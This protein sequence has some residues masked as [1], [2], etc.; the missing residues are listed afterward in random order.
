[1][2]AASVVILGLVLAACHFERADSGRPAGT[3]TAADSVVRSEEDSAAAE[4]VRRML[5]GYYDRV[6]HRGWGALAQ[7]FWRG[8]VISNRWVPP[9]DRAARLSLTGVDEYVRQLREGPGRSASFAVDPVSM[10]VRV[11]GDVAEAWVVYKLRSGTRAAPKTRY[12]VDALH[13]VRHEGAWR[14]VSLAYTAEDPERPLVAPAPP[15]A[16]AGAAAAGAPGASRR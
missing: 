13:L 16:A 7:S 12:G 5:R 1:M 4:P 6:S 10:D 8:A 3:R 2:R 11:Y 15:R 14:I 9:G